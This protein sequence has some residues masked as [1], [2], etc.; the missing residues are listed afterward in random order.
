MLDACCMLDGSWFMDHSQGSWATGAGPAP[1]EGL[2]VRAW[3]R[4]SPRPGARPAKN[5]AIKDEALTIHNR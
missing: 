2:Q 5:Q 1:G 3:A 4:R